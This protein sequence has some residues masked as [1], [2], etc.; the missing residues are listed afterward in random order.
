LAGS[1]EP[2]ERRLAVHSSA[3]PAEWDGG[4]YHAVARPHAAWGATVLDRLE[5]GG[6]ERVL[7]AGCG[8][9]RV[10]AQLLER[11]PN[12]HVIA[13]DVSTSMLDQAR[14]TLADAAAAGRVT[15]LQADLL[16]IDRALDPAVDVIFSTAVFHW[17][18]DHPRLFTALRAV[19]RPMGKLV[20]QCG[21]AG[22]LASF[23]R[24]TDHVASQPPF[25]A[26][27]DGRDLWRFYATPEQTRA[28]LE[29]A[30][31][32]S[33]DAWLEPS[34][35]TF[36]DRK[37]LADFC[38]AVVLTSH[39]AALPTALQTEFVDQVTAEIA[40]REGAFSLDY[41]RLNLQAVA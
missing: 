36:A 9:G 35:Q 38:R 11:L 10:T 20:A 27:L 24:A 1:R 18:P 21:G 12:G 26:V 41:V 39:V 4:L 13:A 23:M 6:T 15:F 22:N 30:G 40:R 14:K 2:R 32:A 33:A 19:V 37:A 16:E 7:D 8:S 31:F 34:P 25:N 17:I 3:M 29:A 5:L 28:R